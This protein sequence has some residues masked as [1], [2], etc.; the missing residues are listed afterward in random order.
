MSERGEVQEVKTFAY[1]P[2]RSR[3]VGVYICRQ[4]RGI[5]GLDN[6]MTKRNHF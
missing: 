6:V 1:I 5:I 4:I 3:I 2:C